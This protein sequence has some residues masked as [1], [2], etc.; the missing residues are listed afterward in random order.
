[1]GESE[2]DDDEVSRLIEEELRS[3]RRRTAIDEILE[4]RRHQPSA[5]DEEIARA[6][7]KDRP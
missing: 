4:L 6:R 3:R 7:R 1:M 5:S 2:P